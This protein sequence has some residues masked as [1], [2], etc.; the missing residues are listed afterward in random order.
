M[1][2]TSQKTR[3]TYNVSKL[4]IRDSSTGIGPLI[5][6]LDRLLATKNSVVNDL[7]FEKTNAVELYII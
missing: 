3:N 1:M 6:L 4:P 2:Y 5:L 7:K